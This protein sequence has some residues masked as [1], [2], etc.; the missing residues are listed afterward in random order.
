MPVHFLLFSHCGHHTLSSAGLCWLDAQSFPGGGV[1]P[2]A[3]SAVW[4]VFL[5]GEAEPVRG[6]RDVSCL[7]ACMLTGLRRAWGAADP[8][9]GTRKWGKED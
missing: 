5:G 4:A 7:G 2:G 8:Q 1:R 9:I 6:G 3:V